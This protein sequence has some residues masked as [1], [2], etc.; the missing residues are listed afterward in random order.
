MEIKS[1][2][3]QYQEELDSQAIL[4]AQNKKINYLLSVVILL[5]ILVV[6][7]MIYAYTKLKSYSAA[8]EEK[9]HRIDTLMR[10]LHHR[11]KNNLQVISSLLGLQSMSIKDE[12]A[13]NW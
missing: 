3:E 11:V 2:V 12:E 1:E 9:N 8:L 4:L 13:K 6:G 5:F 7:G 10:E